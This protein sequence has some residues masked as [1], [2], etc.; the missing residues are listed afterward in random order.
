[1]RA[2][3]RSGSGEDAFDDL[4]G[5]VGEPVVATGVAI[6]VAFVVEPHEMEGRRVEV[7]HVALV[8][9]GAWIIAAPRAEQPALDAMERLVP[10]VRTAYMSEKELAIIA[11]AERYAERYRGEAEKLRASK[12]ERRWKG[13]PMDEY[14]VRRTASFLKSYKEMVRGETFEVREVHVR[15]RDARRAPLGVWCDLEAR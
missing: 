10:A 9:S 7:V 8:A 12:A 15:A 11:D 6:G 2:R 14:Q 3:T 5:D 13:E 4:A 1:M